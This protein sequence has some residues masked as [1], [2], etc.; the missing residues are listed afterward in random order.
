MSLFR[1]FIKA[2]LLSVGD[3]VKGG[4][5]Y[6]S[7]ALTYHFLLSLAPLTIV[8]VNL[9]SLLPVMDPRNIE[10]ITDKIFPQYTLKIVHEILEVQKRSRETSIL[11]LLLSYFFSV[12]FVKHIGRAFSLVSEGRMGEKREI[13]YWFFMPVF[14][15]GTVVLISL[16]FF[17]SVYL[18]LIIP[19]GFALVVEA[20]YI[21]PGTI[22]IFLLYLSFLR[23]EKKVAFLFLTSF[24]VSAL[25]YLMQFLFSFYLAKIFRGN[26]LY[27]SLS[28]VVVFLI[29]M[30][31]I[32]LTLLF[33]ARLIYREENL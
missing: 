32:F 5:T 6:H 26:I 17:L 14:L 9:L 12:G 2:F 28:S 27:G 21:L 24:T 8:L 30:N 15:L 4:Y 31:L 7:G 20:S 29:W 13:F 16:S 23:S 22:V 33:G 11:A 3:V 1:K 10:E 18:K 25:L 19:K